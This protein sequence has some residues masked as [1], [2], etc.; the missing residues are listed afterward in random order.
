M[1]RHLPSQCLVVMR[2]AALPPQLWLRCQGAAT[3]NT[4]GM[5]FSECRLRTARVSSGLC[6]GVAANA[7][8]ST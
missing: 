2:A 7:K 1:A 8:C 4:R 6:Q 3:C 5:F